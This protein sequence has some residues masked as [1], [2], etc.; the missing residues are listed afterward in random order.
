MAR[1]GC[2]DWE[3][4]NGGVRDGETADGTAAHDASVPD[5]SDGGTEAPKTLCIG[6]QLYTLTSHDEFNKDS[7][8]SV[9]DDVAK[10]GNPR[11]WSNG[12]TYGR[13][14][15]TGTDD[16]YY[17]SM[18]TLAAWGA[19]PV[20]ELVPGIGVKLSAYPVPPTHANDKDT[21]CVDGTCRHYVA[22]LLTSGEAYPFGYWEYKAQ[23]PVT[24]G[25]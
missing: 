19:P 14:Q 25:W 16:S 17:P 2:P 3:P 4:R 7:K 23:V 11:M 21:V 15:N 18:A 24:E 9:T 13:Q 10:A 6:G 20:V 12:F 5:G 1:E 8:L 22:G